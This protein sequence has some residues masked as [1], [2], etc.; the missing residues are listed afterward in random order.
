M[1]IYQ[2]EGFNNRREYLASLA[3]DY[4]LH[5]SVVFSIAGVLGSSEDF[6]GLLTMLEDASEL[7]FNLR[8]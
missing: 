6:D 3:E 8:G 1:S 7:D 5:E 2:D 4:G